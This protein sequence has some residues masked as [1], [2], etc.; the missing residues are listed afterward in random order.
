M[1]E[2][3]E[4]LAAYVDAGA[5]KLTEFRPGWFSLDYGWP[6]DLGRLDVDSV[7]DCP[8]A[9][10]FYD[11]DLLGTPYDEGMRLMGLRH[12]LA[13]RFGFDWRLPASSE[14]LNFKAEKDR[15]V[16]TL[17]EL[18]VA[19]IVSLRKFEA[20]ATAHAAEMIVTAEG[21]I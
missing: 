7:M 4:Q 16:A 15:L 12:S 10:V 19:K 3:R 2:T 21:M 18:W 17:N 6:V 13:W 11:E 5:E 14:T 9:Q 1:T 20:Q 8:V